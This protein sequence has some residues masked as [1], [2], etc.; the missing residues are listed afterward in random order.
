MCCAGIGTW[1]PRFGIY[2]G[3]CRS[4]SLRFAWSLFSSLRC[5]GVYVYVTNAAKAPSQ[6]HPCPQPLPPHHRHHH[7]EQLQRRPKQT[8]DLA[9]MPR[10]ASAPALY[11]NSEHEPFYSTAVLVCSRFQASILVHSSMHRQ[12]W[13]VV[14][15]DRLFD[16]S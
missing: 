14:A 9:L 4:F 12:A 3:L 7:H 13:S 10:S 5:S 15:F 11:H 2:S 6:H 8:E 1:V 16:C